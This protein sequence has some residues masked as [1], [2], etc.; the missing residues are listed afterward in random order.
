VGISSVA[1]Y[2]R[3]EAFFPGAVTM[4]Q[5]L[6]DAPAGMLAWILTTDFDG[7]Q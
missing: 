7:D 3:P 6:H 1:A 2:W 4:E 5:M